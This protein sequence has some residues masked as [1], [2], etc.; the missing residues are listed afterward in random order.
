MFEHEY[1]AT[2]PVCEKEI[3]GPGYKVSHPGFD[4]VLW[5][6]SANPWN[7]TCG[8]LNHQYCPI[9]LEKYPGLTWHEAVCHLY[10]NHPYKQ[11]EKVIALK[12]LGRC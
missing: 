10:E 6:L 5:H 12:V 9:C 8:L 2:C 11:F 7:K 1:P 4:Q 3:F